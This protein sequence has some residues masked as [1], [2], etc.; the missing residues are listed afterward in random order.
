MSATNT[1]NQRRE[2]RIDV[3]VPIVVYRGKVPVAAETADVSYKGL[4]VR[5][6][7]PPALRSLVRL[8]VSLADREFEAHAMAVHVVPC[9]D[10]P[11]G[12]PP[13]VGLQ[14]WGL[15]GPNRSAWDDFVRTLVT[16]R[17][18]SARPAASEGRL[19]ATTDVATPSGFHAVA[20]PA[21][22]SA[23]R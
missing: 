20:S 16:A 14:L 21:R 2:P 6:P 17:R 22:V 5:T 23:K 3:R 18:A 19:A 8:K 9:S 12:P 4:F 1:D 13:G 15:A 7:E 10:D 11:E